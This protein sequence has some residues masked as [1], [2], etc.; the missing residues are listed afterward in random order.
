M[1][2]LTSV[3]S[4]ELSPITNF[5]ANTTD[6]NINVSTTDLGANITNVSTT[7]MCIFFDF[8]ITMKCK[9]MNFLSNLLIVLSSS[10]IFIWIL[11]I[12]CN[13]YNKKKMD[14]MWSAPPSKYAS[15]KTRELYYDETTRL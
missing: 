8:S 10:L 14:R 9:T 3:T 12:V 4:V 7:G 6:L 1:L 5:E 2:I 15:S 13:Y 11:C